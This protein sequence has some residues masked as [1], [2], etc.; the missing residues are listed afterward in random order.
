[1]ALH[2]RSKVSHWIGTP[3]ART[4]S[5]QDS[6]PQPQSAKAQLAL[7]GTG[8]RRPRLSQPWL[9][10]GIAQQDAMQHRASAAQQDTVRPHAL[11]PLQRLCLALSKRAIIVMHARRRAARR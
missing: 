1:M 8:D 10:V 9:H 2:D 5:K 3:L 6:K 11:R 4:I 7:L